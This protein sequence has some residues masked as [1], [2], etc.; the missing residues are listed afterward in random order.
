MQIHL[1]KPMLSQN[2][3]PPSLS[4]PEKSDYEL[5][6]DANVARIARKKEELLL[7]Q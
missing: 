3:G 5:Q 6:R 7:Q 1:L 4:L 2:A